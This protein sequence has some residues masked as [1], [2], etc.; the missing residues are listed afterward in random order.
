M[1]RAWIV[2]LAVLP[3]CA[4]ACNGLD[5]ERML[6]QPRYTAYEACDVC[7]DG[8]IMMQPPAGTVA[9]DTAALPEAVRDGRTAGRY[10]ADIP[11]PVDARVLARGRDRFDIYCA[12]CHGRLGDGVSQVAENMRLRKPANLLAP[13]YAT[14]PPGRIYAVITQGFGL[15]RSYASEL[16]VADRWAVVAYV[17]ALRLSQGLAL[18]QLPPPI[19]EEAQ[20][21]LK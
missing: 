16:P 21:W 9:R 7:A 18:D 14:Y 10:V 8:T 19:R 3:A 4:R 20:R 2:A 13:P 5:L 12:A 6:D 1:S 15:M 17:E 11:V